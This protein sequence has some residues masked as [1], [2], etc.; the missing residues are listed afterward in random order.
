MAILDKWYN[1]EGLGRQDQNG[2]DQIKN[3]VVDVKK[4][5]VFV[6]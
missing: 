4:L 5:S 6:K 1:G 2:F 3:T